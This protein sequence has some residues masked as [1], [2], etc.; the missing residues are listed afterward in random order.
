VNPRDRTIATALLAAV[1]LSAAAF[2]FYEFYLV[3][4]GDRQDR[5]AKALEQD[6]QRTS[7]LLQVEEHQK[8]MAE[9]RKLS[10]PG[11]IN[12]DRINYPHLL[13][14]MVQR[15]G[16]Q[17]RDMQV[18]FKDSTDIVKGGI[19]DKK[20]PFITPISFTITGRTDLD[21]LLKLLK[22][23][24]TTSLLHRIKAFS[25]TRPKTGV[26]GKPGNHKSRDLQVTLEVEAL[27][28]KG[29]DVRDDILPK[30][31]PAIQTLARP[32]GEYLALASKKNIFYGPPPPPPARAADGSDPS[33]S[34]HFT[35]ISRTEDGECEVNL[36]DVN[37]LTRWRLYPERKRDP[38][39][40]FEIKNRSGEL[41]VQGEVTR[42]LGVD[43]IIFRSGGRYYKMHIG[44][45]VAEAMRKPLNEAQVQAL[46]STRAPAGHPIRAAGNNGPQ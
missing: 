11:D 16:I 29:A 40:V 37:E 26:D 46:Q 12:L 28:V 39:D 15:S 20:E 19:F 38:K 32:V 13:E 35:G 8:Q 43:D 22:E 6:K 45:S 17:A 2:L 23:F 30:S 41:K 3:P 10:L 36:C 9:W 25:V 1:A 21:G 14:G 44:E 4:R 7:R 24:Y 42:I 5:L 31:P 34:V 18:N 33:A 27:M